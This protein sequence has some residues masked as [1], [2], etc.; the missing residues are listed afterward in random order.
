MKVGLRWFATCLLL[1][2]I[3][4]AAEACP[5]CYGGDGTTTVG[6]MNQAILF[7]LGV[8]GTVLAGISTFF[9]YMWKRIRTQRRIVSDS[10]FVNA[11]GNLR[12]VN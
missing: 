12:Q 6:G 10:I 9:V 4:R 5:V 7:L 11:N 3:Q 1:L 2:S 8:T